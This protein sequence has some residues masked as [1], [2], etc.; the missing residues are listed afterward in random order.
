LLSAS[1]IAAKFNLDRNTNAKTLRSNADKYRRIAVF[2][3]RTQL[4]N[5]KKR[6][7]GLGLAIVKRIATAHDGSAWVEPNA[8]QGN[9]FCLRIPS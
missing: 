6:G 3:R 8:P 9:R 4:E 7:R 5:G 2:E 1:W